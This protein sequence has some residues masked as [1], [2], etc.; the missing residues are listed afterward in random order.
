VNNNS[1]HAS[2]KTRTLKGKYWKGKHEFPNTSII[3][4]GYSF[5]CGTSWGQVMVRSVPRFVYKL[6]EFSTVQ[7]GQASRYEMIVPFTLE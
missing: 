6:Q 4:V 7:Q 5:R 2:L 1:N 3:T